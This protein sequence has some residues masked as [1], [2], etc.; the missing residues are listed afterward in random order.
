MTA[1]P[2]MVRCPLCERVL[3]TRGLPGHVRAMHRHG[4]DMRGTLLTGTA[5]DGIPVDHD[6]VPVG[7]G[8]S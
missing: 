3:S 8:A 1:A 4:T 5:A 2:R 7:E 6:G